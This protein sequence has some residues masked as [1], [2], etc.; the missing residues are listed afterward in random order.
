MKR[1]PKG[2]WALKAKDTH[3]KRDLCR[4]DTCVDRSEKRAIMERPSR[5]VRFARDKWFKEKRYTFVLERLGPFASRFGTKIIFKTFTLRNEA[6]SSYRICTSHYG[7]QFRRIRIKRRTSCV[8]CRLYRQNRIGPAIANASVVI[9][10]IGASEKEIFDIT[11][12][13]RIDYQATKNLIDAA[14]V[15]GVNH[16]ILVTSLGTNKIGFPAAILNLFWGVLIWKRKAEEAL[17]ASGLPYTIVRPGGMERPTDSYKET[18]NVSLSKEDTLFGGLVSNL[19]VAELMAFMT[20][21]RDLSSYKV[22]EVIAETTAPLSPFGE[23]LSKIPSKRVDRSS[24]KE[25]K[26]APSTVAV[27]TS[28]ANGKEPPSKTPLLNVGPSSYIMNE[29]LKSPTPKTPTPAAPSSTKGDSSVVRAVSESIIAAS[30]ANNSGSTTTTT[31]TISTPPKVQK[32]MPLS[33]YFFYED[34]KPPTSP[35]PSANAQKIEAVAAAKPENESVSS[36]SGD[37]TSDKV[38]N[39][40]HSSE[41]KARPLSPFTMYEDLKPPSSPVPSPKK[42]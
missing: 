37:A 35:T 22:V 14:T 39:K 8:C 10:C 18:H 26:S 28:S 29:D 38:D 11:G 9:C 15:A 31:E 24:L 3:K 34:L 21:N 33:P 12:P 16:F 27:A 5:A 4:E 1:A 32:T 13:Y 7:I 6:S 19:Q 2:P 30:D 25:P 41:P 23:L 40:T 20:K 42:C 17:I 36:S